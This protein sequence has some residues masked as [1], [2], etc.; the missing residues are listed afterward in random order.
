MNSSL[1]ASLVA[2]ITGWLN[3]QP[4]ARP[5]LMML[6]GAAMITKQ[7][8]PNPNVQH[9]MN[10]ILAIT[11]SLGAGSVGQSNSGLT[12]SSPALRALPPPSP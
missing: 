2:P 7:Y 6:T 5:A 4:W 9:A 1:L 12:P 8:A 11:L 3:A 10:V